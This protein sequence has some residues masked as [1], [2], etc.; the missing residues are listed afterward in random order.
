[1]SSPTKTQIVSTGSNEIMIKEKY[2]SHGAVSANF[3]SFSFRDERI[4]EI[5]DFKE[6]KINDSLIKVN[7]FNKDAKRKILL[8]SNM[9]NHIQCYHIKHKMKPDASFAY[10]SNLTPA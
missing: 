7:Y 3:S 2:A 10:Q 1:M 5:F 8:T 9:S 4:Y 6:H